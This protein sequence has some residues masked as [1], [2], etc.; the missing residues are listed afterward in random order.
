MAVAVAAAAP[1]PSLA[2]ERPSLRARPKPALLPLEVAPELRRLSRFKSR[3]EGFETKLSEAGAP[4]R[5]LT[6]GAAL[7]F[8]SCCISRCSISYASWARHGLEGGESSHGCGLGKW[9][10]V[11]GHPSSV[12]AAGSGRVV[13]PLAGRD[14]TPSMAPPTLVDVLLAERGDEGRAGRAVESSVCIGGAE[15]S[16]GYDAGARRIDAPAEG[17][18]RPLGVWLFTTTLTEGCCGARKLGAP[19]CC[20]TS[21]AAMSAAA[22]RR[23]G[24]STAR[25]ERGRRSEKS[26]TRL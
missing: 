23:R 3:V 24:R 6:G 25:A 22:A 26:S 13:L 4:S 21:K 1:I 12:S 7:A 11:C 5:A 8:A 15:A 18:D 16:A 17:L 20:R 10:S 19:E 14:V 9:T 2:C